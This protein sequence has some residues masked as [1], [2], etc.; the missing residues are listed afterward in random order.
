[1][2]HSYIFEEGNWK[3][4]GLYFDQACNEIEVY[5]ETTIKHL[6]AEWILDGFMEL[7][8]EKPVRFL[9]RGVRFGIFIFSLWYGRCD[10]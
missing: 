5:G 2:R 7:K 4:A 3:A 1:M 10:V 8:T 6:K 9:E